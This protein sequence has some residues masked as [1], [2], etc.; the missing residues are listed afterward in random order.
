M[1][2][3]KAQ[4]SV[5]IHWIFILIAGAIILTFF[6]TIVVKQKDISEQKIA[7]KAIDS[8]EQIITATGVTE[9]TFN[10]IDIPKIKFEFICN[11]DYSEYSILK[12]GLNRNL[13]TEIV[14][15]PDIVQGNS[16]FIWSLTWNFPF[17]VDNFVMITSPE[18]RYII[19][20]D[21]EKDLEAQ[22]IFDDIPDPINKEQPIPIDKLNQLKDKG[23]Y[24]IKLI[25]VTEQ[26][27]LDTALPK[28]MEKEDIS[29]VRIAGSY[30]NFYEK[31]GL[32]LYT[33]R[34]RDYFDINEPFPQDEKDPMLY[35]AI[36]AENPE[37]YSCAMKKAYN[38]LSL[39]AK[40]HKQRIAILEDYYSEKE[41]Y[42]IPECSL[43]Y[44]PD[45]EHPDYNKFIQYAQTCSDNPNQCLFTNLN[46]IAEEIKDNNIGISRTIACPL[47]Y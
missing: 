4:V 46:N 28:W 36:F 42:Q 37:M 20:Y 13:E 44:D 12:T 24:K 19:L 2:H 47:I 25:F 33:K 7:G 14:F 9:D 21:D 31:Q 1:T 34:E 26:E 40:V 30:I 45:S 38:R 22:Y 41:R 43:L 27:I 10:K 16:V 11:Q 35:A 3:K 5:H 23:N 39:T 17:A 15:S 32:K 8:F 29:A 18:V 6:V